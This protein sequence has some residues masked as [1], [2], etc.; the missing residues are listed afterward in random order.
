MPC[1]SS[2]RLGGT[3]RVNTV[4]CGWRCAI[5]WI[6]GET[7]F[8]HG[9]CQGVSSANIRCISMHKWY[10]GTVVHRLLPPTQT[11]IAESGSQRWKLVGYRASVWD[12]AADVAPSQ[13]RRLIGS[14]HQPFVGPARAYL[15]YAYGITDSHAAN[16]MLCCVVKCENALIGRNCLVIDSFYSDL[17]PRAVGP[18]SLILL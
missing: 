11:T 3:K 18:K 7:S 2:A 6:C 15:L 17:F 9:T 8:I 5:S 10:P 14:P 12:K 1:M 16:K 13:T 4:R